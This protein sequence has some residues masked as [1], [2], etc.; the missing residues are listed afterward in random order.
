MNFLI[1][2]NSARFGWQIR[3]AF[4]NSCLCNPALHS[5]CWPT[6]LKNSPTPSLEACG[7]CPPPSAHRHRWKFILRAEKFHRVG[8]RILGSCRKGPSQDSRDP[9]ESGNS[10]RPSIIGGRRSASPVSRCLTHS[11]CQLPVT[12]LST[13]PRDCFCSR[14]CLIDLSGSLEWGLCRRGRSEIP[15]LSAK[16]SYLPLHKGKTGQ[17]TEKN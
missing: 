11:V 15:H 6:P 14:L 2:T 3:H 8:M 13:T 17:K 9:P 5:T 7:D 4:E 16:S 1:I 12:I 10:E